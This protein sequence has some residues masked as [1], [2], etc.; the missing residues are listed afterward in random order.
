MGGYVYM[1]GV[2]APEDEARV[3]VFDRG[4]NYGDGLFETM[5]AR[6]AEVLFLKEH[7]N[8]LKEGAGAIGIPLKTLKGLDADIRR[9]ALHEL[10]RKNGIGNALSYIKIIVT[11]GDAPA[12]GALARPT[13]VIVCR[14]IDEKN[15]LRRQKRG[16]KAVVVKDLRPA[17][18]WVKSLNYLPNILARAEA[19]RKG[20]YE[21]IFT[22]ADS[23]LLEGASTNLFLVEGGRVK[24][25]PARRRG[26]VGGVLPGIMRGKVMELAL[27]EGIRVIESP[28]YVEDLAKAE[29]AFLT[30]S[31]FDIVPLLSVDSRPV[32]CGKAGPVTRVL[33]ERLKIFTESGA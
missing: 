22:G 8:R 17:I 33:Q 18:P 3:S 23:S 27:R 21:A 29:E 26:A 14:P 5:K 12:P 24:T 32:G 15:V 7:L 2:I 19:E 6:G 4:F 11:G 30:N 10:L 25:P 13:T 28:L 31:I 20:A 1:N 16:V 9:G